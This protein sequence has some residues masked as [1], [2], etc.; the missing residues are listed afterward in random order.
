MA[1][2]L[3]Y[4]Q[5]LNEEVVILGCQTDDS[6]RDREL[7]AHIRERSFRS[8]FDCNEF[9]GLQPCHPF[10]FRQLLPFLFSSELDSTQFGDAVWWRL[11]A[12]FVSVEAFALPSSRS[13]F[14]LTLPE[15]G[16][17]DAG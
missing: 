15:L 11:V 12:F 16:T 2:E 3:E 14:L 5:S 4:F 13:A 8:K 7:A 17:G 1:L 9:L 6:S 10:R